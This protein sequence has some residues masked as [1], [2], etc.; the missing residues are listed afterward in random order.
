MFSFF[1]ILLLIV[2]I[3]AITELLSKSEIFS[4]FREFFF[5]RRKYSGICKFTHALLDCGYCTSVWASL[6]LVSMW[7]L[8]YNNKC[9]KFFLIVIA[10]HRL[11]NL[12]HFVLDRVWGRHN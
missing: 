6:F 2:S 8:F 9:F 7:E 4:P 3:E 12:F 1:D 10:L 5:N 11:S